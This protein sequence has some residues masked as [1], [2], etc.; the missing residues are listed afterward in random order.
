MK[1]KK[2]ILITSI[3]LMLLFVLSSA[4]YATCTDIA[5]GKDASVDGSVMTSHTGCGP[6]CRVHV[7]PAQDHEPGAM[8]PVY[9][10]GTLANWSGITRPY[11]DYGEVIGE[12]PQVKHTYG[13]FHTAYP[14]M[15]EY[16]LAIGESTLSQK[17]E[18]V[19]HYGIAKQIMTVEM[20]QIFALQRCKTAKHAVEVITSLSEEY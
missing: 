19:A 9:W 16:Q 15:N 14:Q 3:T 18:L 2:L 12:I 10:G 8:A 7:V 17:E 5:V 13:Y 6:E 1:M 20:L 4:V 11:N